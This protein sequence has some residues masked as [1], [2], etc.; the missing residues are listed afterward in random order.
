MDTLSQELL[1]EE[2][3]PP[4]IPATADAIPTQEINNT[5]APATA[6]APPPINNFFSFPIMHHQQTTSFPEQTD[7]P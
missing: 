4:I 1:S 5:V 3:L 7:G 2:L 6:V